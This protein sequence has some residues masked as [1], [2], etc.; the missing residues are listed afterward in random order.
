MLSATL[1]FFLMTTWGAV[2]EGEAQGERGLSEGE[3]QGEGFE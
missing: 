1:R 2:G 3:A